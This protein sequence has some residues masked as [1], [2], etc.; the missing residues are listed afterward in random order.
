MQQKARFR[1]NPYSSE[2]LYLMYLLYFIIYNT[3]PTVTEFVL[4]YCRFRTLVSVHVGIY[5]VAITCTRQKWRLVVSIKLCTNL[6]QFLIHKATGCCSWCS[7]TSIWVL[8]RLVPYYE[9]N[10]RSMAIVVNILGL[11]SMLGKPNYTIIY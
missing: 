2:F 4:S 10:R 5:I 7:F 9:T 3:T 1:I 11:K 6:W 8:V